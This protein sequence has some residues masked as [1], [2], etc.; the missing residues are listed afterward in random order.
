M[1]KIL[2]KPI[3]Q[4]FCSET[5]TMSEIQ[6]TSLVIVNAY[7]PRIETSHSCKRPNSKDR[8]LFLL[9]N[10]L[11]RT[12][13]CA[14][15]GLH[16]QALLQHHYHVSKDRPWSRLALGG[17]PLFPSHQ[18]HPIFMLMSASSFR[19]WPPF[20]PRFLYLLKGGQG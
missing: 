14:G 16:R 19:V 17:C 1:S 9:A 5:N 11:P 7:S 3:V 13:H 10:H 15:W 2:Q 4:K 6:S 12:I 8:R 20:T 18:F